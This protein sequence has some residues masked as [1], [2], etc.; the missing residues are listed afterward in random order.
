MKKIYFLFMLFGL[1]SLMPL[2]GFCVEPPVPAPLAEVG[3]Q[4]PDFMLLDTYGNTHSLSEYAGKYVVLEWVNHDCPFVKKHYNTGNMQSL[5]K[6]AAEKGV[7][8]ISINSSAAGKQGNFSAEMWNQLTEEKGAMPSTVLLDPEGVV[9]KVYNA[10]TTP[11]MYIINPE[12]TLVYAGAIDSIPSVDEED[13]SE[14]Q[15][16]VKAALEES[17][18]GKAVTVSS[19]KAYGCSVKYA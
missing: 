10:Q 1:F 3:A 14:A 12:G 9:G 6:Y 7:A 2:Q 11:H 19:T 15:N 13:I 4:A 17:L 5:Q 8:W 18:A 16:Y